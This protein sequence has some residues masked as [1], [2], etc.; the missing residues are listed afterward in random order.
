[1]TPEERAT[2][3]HEALQDRLRIWNHPRTAHATA[4]L[5]QESSIELIA[6]ALKAAADEERQEILSILDHRL[7]GQEDDYQFATKHKLGSDMCHFWMATALRRAIGAI[8]QLREGAPP[9]E[10]NQ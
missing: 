7:E 3:L 10:E 6:A 9:H 4:H 1:M 5:D 2:E 8:R